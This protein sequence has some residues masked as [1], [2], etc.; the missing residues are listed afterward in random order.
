M[1]YDRFSENNGQV[2]GVVAGEWGRGVTDDGE[3]GCGKQRGI[4]GCRQRME[5]ERRFSNRFSNS[6]VYLA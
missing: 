5:V 2:S 3:S 6:L 4:D 1:N